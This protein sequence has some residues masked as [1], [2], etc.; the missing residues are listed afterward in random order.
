MSREKIAYDALNGITQY[1]NY[2]ADTD[3]SVFESSGDAEPVLELNRAMANDRDFTKQGIKDE[4]WLYARIPTIFQ[5][6]LLTE[7]GIDVYKKSDGHRLSKILEDPEY[8]HLKTTTLK[9]IIKP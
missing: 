6:K 8:R 4:F 3:T 1:H 7:K 9:H 5:L 2:D